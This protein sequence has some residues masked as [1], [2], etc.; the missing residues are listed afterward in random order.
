MYVIDNLTVS[1]NTS[2]VLITAAEIWGAI[3]GLQ[4]FSQMVYYNK[5]V[6]KVSSVSTILLF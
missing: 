6:K 3:R 5:S 4:T 2:T 1:G